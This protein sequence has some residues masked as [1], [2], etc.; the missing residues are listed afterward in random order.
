M[1]KFVNPKQHFPLLLC[2]DNKFTTTIKIQLSYAEQT[3]HQNLSYSQGSN[4]NDCATKIISKV[5]KG[6]V[7][8]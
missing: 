3:K 5:Q 2:A 1:M 8:E 7:Q 6:Y 4:R